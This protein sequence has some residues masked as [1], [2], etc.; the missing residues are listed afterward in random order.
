M[1]QKQK[2]TESCATNGYL[3]SKYSVDN[4]NV[5]ADVCM[6]MPACMLMTKSKQLNAQ[7]F[8]QAGTCSFNFGMMTTRNDIIVMIF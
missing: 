6:C 7:C 3:C 4:N 8:Y 2:N 1:K 5:S